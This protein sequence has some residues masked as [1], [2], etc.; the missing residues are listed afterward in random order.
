LWLI[1]KNRFPSVI[2]LLG[3]HPLFA[4]GAFEVD[5]WGAH[6]AAMGGA[7]SAH[8][9]TAEGS[10]FNPALAASMQV[11]M[12]SSTHAKLFKGVPGGLKQNSVGGV[13]PTQYGGITLSFAQFGNDG[14]SEQMFDIGF[15][16]RVHER[17]SLGLQLENKGWAY[18]DWERRSWSASVGGV[19]E[20]G[21]ITPH[22]YA[23][24]GLVANGLGGDKK[25]ARG[26]T[27]HSPARYIVAAEIRPDQQIFAAE[28]VKSSDE[29]EIRAGCETSLIGDWKLRFGGNI[30]SADT[31]NRSVSI[32]LGYTWS[33]I[34]FD[35]AYTHSYDL[36]SF[37]AT[38]RI[39]IGLFG[40]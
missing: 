12:F 16:R 36:S 19:Y 1:N 31:L 22:T 34:S 11:K 24:M 15:A 29:W 21:W 8:V 32:G 38:H 14:Y 18:G 6:S 40:S 2:L 26:L 7:F 13:V 23:R 20:I 37:G 5:Q 17:V 27:G 35:Y 39:G 30:L 3:L 25:D 10:W 4:F 9:G 33:S 28:V